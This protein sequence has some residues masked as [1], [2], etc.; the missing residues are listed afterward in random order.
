MPCR[1]QQF[2]IHTRPFHI[3]IGQGGPGWISP[4][5]AHALALQNP[6]L[7][8]GLLFRAVSQT[9]LHIAAD[10]RRLGARIGFLTVLHTDAVLPFP[11][12]QALDRVDKQLDRL[13]GSERESD[14]W[15]HF[16]LL[17]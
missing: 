11:L 4:F 1:A 13:I 15:A 10:A 16:R 14:G 8:Y 6:Q 7:V 17:S 12:R 3:R 9:L 5:V 2:E